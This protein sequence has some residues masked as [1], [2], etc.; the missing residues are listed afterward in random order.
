MVS[1]LEYIWIG[2][3][4]CLRSKTKVLNNS[5]TSLNDIPKWNFDG[6]STGQA[7][8]EHSKSL[9]TEVILQPVKYCLDPFRRFNSYLV[10]CETYD[11]SGNPIFNNYRNAAN[12]IFNN[13]LDEPWFGLEQEYF[14]VYTSWPVKLDQG[15]YYCGVGNKDSFE[16]LIANEHLDLCLEAGLTISGINAEV[17]PYQ[18]EFQVGPCVG[19]DSGD[20]LYLARYILERVAEKYNVII[21]Y[22]PKICKELNGSGCHAN[23]STKKMR[24]PDG[25]T[26]I[27]ECMSK[28]EKVHKEHLLVY[29]DG[30]EERLTGHHE[31][32]S[33]DIF[34]FG[35]G[36]RHTSI[37]IPNQT[38]LD[39]CGYFEDRRPAANMDPY[40]VTSTLYKTCCL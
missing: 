25:I 31:T 35:V 30:N 8:L 38:V 36:T 1:I 9:D 26:H 23:F 15:P 7:G 5:I 21:N 34:T 6:S 27:Y 20:Q 14:M 22:K 10:L 39:G 29:G 12:K 11:T 24:E 18:W 2:G 3:N 33:M 40:L 17:A 13:S 32:A 16:R 19:I 28:L 4:S 37:R